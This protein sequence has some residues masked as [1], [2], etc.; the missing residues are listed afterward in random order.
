MEIKHKDLILDESKPFLHCKLDRQRNAGVLTSIVQTYAEGFVLALNGKWGTGKTTFVKMWQ[1]SLQHSG[2]KTIYFNAW[3]NDFENEPLTALLGELKK[4]VN[5][6][7]DSYK[8][9]LNKG[10]IIT[11]NILP[12][13]A[14]GVISKYLDAG[15]TLDVLEK[16]IDAATDILDKEVDNYVDKKQGLVDFRKELENYIQTNNEGK[17]VIFI[18][19]ELDRCRPDYA[20][21][22]LEKVK[23]FFSVKGII[24]VLSIDKMQLGHS[25]RGYYGT[26]K[27][28]TDEYLR[29]FIDL[30]YK[31]PIPNTKAFC[32]Y[33]YD[34]YQFYEFFDSRER[35]QYNQ[36][37]GDGD[38]FKKFTS[39]LF[40]IYNYTLRQQEK[41]FAHSRIVLRSFST[42]S[43]VFPHLFMLLIHLKESE[44]EFYNNIK[45]LKISIQELVSNYEMI[46]Q[47]ILRDELINEYNKEF[48]HAESLLILFYNNNL[49]KSS[50]RIRNNSELVI[51]KDNENQ[52]SFDTTD[53]DKFRNTLLRFLT[54]NLNYEFSSFELS[55][56]I[57]KIELL[58]NIN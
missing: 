23:H 32:D 49:V 47:S 27:F 14:K 17:P 51:I 12:A 9:L 48:I 10:V 45:D 5:N 33:L 54:N 2:H 1:L 6:K 26:E 53:D 24:F 20:V 11:K 22:V 36:L 37:K 56:I 13:L 28:D 4:L 18:I 35:N 44:P 42:A 30:E 52:L 3:E 50:N 46:F 8:S 34:Y 39:R 15:I 57:N 31:L 55:L 41:I 25:I 29:R 16:S 40:S 19:D 38:R 21:E 7:T 58:E 43:F